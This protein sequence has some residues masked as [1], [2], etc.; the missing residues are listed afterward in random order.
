V[1]FATVQGYVESKNHTNCLG[2]KVSG[3]KL[4]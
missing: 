1:E 2:L 4:T 3:W